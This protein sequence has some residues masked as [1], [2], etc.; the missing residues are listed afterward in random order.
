MNN[1]WDKLAGKLT[2]SQISDNM[3]LYYGALVRS[4]EK[5]KEMYRST[6]NKC[7]NISL[8]PAKGPASLAIF[9]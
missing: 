6:E 4:P 5:K 7:G 9:T 2:A 1:R 8:L 3:N